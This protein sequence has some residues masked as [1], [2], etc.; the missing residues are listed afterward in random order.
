[1]PQGI[2]LP[3]RALDIILISSRVS[4]GSGWSRELTRRTAAELGNAG[5]RV[6]WLCPVGAG[7]EPPSVDGVEVATARATPARWRLVQSPIE[8]PA[9]ELLLTAEIRRALPEAVHVIGFGTGASSSLLWIA[10]RM[11]VAPLVTLR[12]R[13]LLCHRQTL[14]DEQGRPCRAWADVRRCAE[15]CLTAT[16]HGLTPGQSRLGRWLRPLGGWSPFPNQHAFL[17]R[18]EMILGGVDNA[19]TILVEREEDRQLLVQAGISVAIRV[20]DLDREHGVAL[21]ELYSEAELVS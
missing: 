20:V 9:M 12:A 2:K 18:L 4:G 16:P 14:V 13:E 21:L 7:E 8:G 15:C 1:M 5:H 17:N 10:R 3:F 11:G 19:E 6:R